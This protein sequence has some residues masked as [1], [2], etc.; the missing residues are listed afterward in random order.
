MHFHLLIILVI[1][2]GGKRKSVMLPDPHAADVELAMVET[3]VYGLMRKET[4][5]VNLGR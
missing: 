3:Y 5:A 1:K 4:E 2:V